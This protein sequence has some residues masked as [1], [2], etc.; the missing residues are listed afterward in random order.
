MQPSHDRAKYLLRFDDLCPAMNWNI[1]SDIEEALVQRGIKP[2]LAVVPDNQDAKLQVEAPVDDFWERVRTWQSWGWTIGLHGFQHKYVTRH[3]GIV[4]ARTKSEFAGLTARDQG[5]K[6][7]RGAEI[8]ARQGIRSSV[9]IAPN[10]SF[11]WTTVTLLSGLGMSII[12][13]GQF[14]FPYVCAQE[15]F[16]VPQQ[17]SR[18]RPA[19]AGMWT[20]CY[21]HNKWTPAMLAQFQRDLD[22]YGDDIWPLEKVVKT[23]SERRSQWSDWLCK[24]PRFSSL[25]IRCE[26]KAWSLCRCQPPSGGGRQEAPVPMP[27]RIISRQ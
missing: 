19:P 13:D 5:E 4:T 15:M 6:L 16:W 27:D 11:D 10:H 18:L 2:L 7:R 20:V 17:L 22:R 25:L 3:T 9:W 8:F 12:S 24:H 21:H 14:R 26:L 23:W 1:W